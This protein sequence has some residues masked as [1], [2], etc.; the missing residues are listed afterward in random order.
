MTPE[1]IHPG[2]ILSRELKERGITQKQLA[3]MLSRP[4]KWVSEIITGRK[5]I[6]AES[7]LDFELALGIRADNWL[8]LQSAYDLAKARSGYSKSLKTTSKPKNGKNGRVG[9]GKIEQKKDQVIE[10]SKTYKPFEIAQMFGWS[11]TGVV[12]ALK[13]WGII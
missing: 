5:S 3:E 13:R 9:K 12:A 1:A 8:N 6:T 4:Q 2:R 11:E 7:A 10:L